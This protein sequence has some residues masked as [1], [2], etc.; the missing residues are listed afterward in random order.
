MTLLLWKQLFPQQKRH[1]LSRPRRLPGR[2]RSGAGRLDPAGDLA[3]GDPAAAGAGGG[4]AQHHLV[5]VLE[6]RAAVRAE[7][8]LAAPAELEERAALVRARAR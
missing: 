4:V 6:E 5:A 3:E 2:P 7:R 1:G 8:L